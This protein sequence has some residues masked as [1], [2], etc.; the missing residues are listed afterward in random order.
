ML[1]TSPENFQAVNTDEEITFSANV[2]DP[3]GATPL[4]LIWTV[5]LNGG[6][7]EQVGTGN[8]VFWTPHDTIDFSD[9]GTR[10][11]TIRLTAQDPGGN[12]GNDF[13][14]LRF[15]IVN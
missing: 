7:P 9:G 15:F 4:T 14:Q 5:A 3:E 13:V 6:A 8:N 1:V 2:T 12:R 11:V 10:N